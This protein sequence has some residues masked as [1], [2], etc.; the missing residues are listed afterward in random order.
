MGD[1]PRCIDDALMCERLARQYLATPGSFSSVGE[2]IAASS[3]GWCIESLKSLQDFAQV[4][5][6]LT[7]KAA[8]FKKAGLT[9][10]L[11]FTAVELA[12]LQLH[13]HDHKRALMY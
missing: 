1:Y 13:K 5:Q 6:M 9:R 3:H 7:N 4:E 12:E 2:G 8:E 11:G 10:Y